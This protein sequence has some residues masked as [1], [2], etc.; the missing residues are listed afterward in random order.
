ME[1]ITPVPQKVFIINESMETLLYVSAGLA[2]LNLVTHSFFT[3]RDPDALIKK[4]PALGPCIVITGFLTCV[5][6]INGEEVANRVKIKNKEAQIFIVTEKVVKS[7][8]FVKIYKIKSGDKD[9]TDKQR[10]ESILDIIKPPSKGNVY[11]KTIGYFLSRF[12]VHRKN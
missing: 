2:S 3:D 10:L 5:E 4:I 12:K 6:G 8:L 7:N 11:E 1:T 9:K